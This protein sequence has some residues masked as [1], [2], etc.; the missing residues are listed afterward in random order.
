M[1]IEILIFHH[2]FNYTNIYNTTLGEKFRENLL[3]SELVAYFHK[4]LLYINK[5]QTKAK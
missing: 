3:V 2:C 5:Q 1:K 4:H